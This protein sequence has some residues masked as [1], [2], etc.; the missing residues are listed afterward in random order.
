MIP[1]FHKENSCCKTDPSH[2]VLTLLLI[3]CGERMQVE[4]VQKTRFP[5]FV[6]PFFN[7]LYL[8]ED[9]NDE[10]FHIFSSLK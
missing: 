8:R 2:G 9:E 4:V 10:Q 5:G 1:H 7:C 3:F 6:F